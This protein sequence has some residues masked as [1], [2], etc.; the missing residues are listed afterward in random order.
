MP[1]LITVK[2]DDTHPRAHDFAEELVAE[3]QTVIDDTEIAGVPLSWGQSTLVERAQAAL[4]AWDEAC[5]NLVGEFD[6]GDMLAEILSTLV[7]LEPAQ[8]PAT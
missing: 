6:A 3:I 1:I 7:N 5:K 4:A 2:I 8:C